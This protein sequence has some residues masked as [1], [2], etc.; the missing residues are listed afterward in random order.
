MKLDAKQRSQFKTQF[1]PSF[2]TALK[3]LTPQYLIKNPV[4]FVTYIGT[5]FLT[6]LYIYS[7]F[8]NHSSLGYILQV[9][10]WLWLTIIIANFSESLAENR[11]K[12][13]AGSLRK[14]KKEVQAKKINS[15]NDRNFS[16]VQAIQLRNQ[17]IVFVAAG[18]VI[19]GDGEVIAGVAAVDESAITGE[20][21]PVIRESGSDR[22]SVT[23]GTVVLSDWLVVRITSNPGETF[24]DQMI[25][26]VEGAK[27]QRTPNEIALS[28]LL[29]GMTLIFLMV[30]MTILP[31]SLFGGT[32]PSLSPAINLTTLIALLVC[33]IPTTIGGLLSAIGI[34]G[35]DRLI[36][37]NVIATS[38][39]AIEAAGDV[40]ILLLDKTGTI[41]MGNRQASDFV[42]ASGTTLEELV[43]AASL[44]SFA[45]ETPEGKSIIQLAQNKYQLDLATIKQ[46]GNFIPFSAETRLSGIEINGKKTLKGAV[47]KIVAFVKDNQGVID[48]GIL[49]RIND[50]ARLGSTPLVVANEAKILGVIELKDIIKQGIKEKLAGLRI[51]GIKSIMITGD[52]PITAATIANETGVDDFYAEATPEIKLKLIR[53]FQANGQLVAMVGDGT[54][55]APALAQTDVAVAMNSGTQAAKEAANMVDLDSDPTKVI[56]IVKIGKQ[57]LITRGALTTFSIAN[58]VAKYFA[59]IP[60]IFSAYIPEINKLN[61]MNLTSPKSAV[62]STVIFNA[63]ILIFLIPLAFKG[64]KYIAQSA[65]ALLLR[66][67]LIYGVGGVVLPFFAIKIIDLFINWIGII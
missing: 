44:A 61:I 41:T 22:D 63:L 6:F 52:N 50:I 57:L 33:L 32:R 37:N 43:K 14:A 53:Q 26:L 20:S 4:L 27:R 56:E 3:H 48:E 24:L 9:M 1:W 46:E 19:P 29:A 18:D 7:W 45:D 67:T 8:K 30:V 5:L 42:P 15:I 36:R 38:G 47:D 65:D 59:I 40:N 66:N 28:I 34:A 16:L 51:M 13:Q 12:A 39:R 64:V 10:L 35:M 49:K 62:L 2:L 11:G 17:D 58:D 31:F 54:N 55:D 21:A 23:G 25:A 60:G